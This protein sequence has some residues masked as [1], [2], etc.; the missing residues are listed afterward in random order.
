MLRKTLISIHLYLAAFF[1]PVLI[2]VAISGGLYL[3]GEKGDTVQEILYS[4]SVTV[5]N[6]KAE[7][8]K[9]EVTNVLQIIGV[10]ASFETVKGGGDFFYTRP[11][12]KD[13]YV[14]EIKNEQLQITKHSPNLNKIIVELHK[15]HGPK[16]FKLFQQVLA[17]GLLFI[18][19]SGLWLGLSSP[20]L[21]NKSLIASGLGGAIFLVLALF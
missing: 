10:N 11:S 12:S 18:V 14:F 4:G 21:R 20:M 1:A 15:G 9:T 16:A 17:I 19:V 3:F 5:F 7:D 8:L 13:F 6:S 2:I